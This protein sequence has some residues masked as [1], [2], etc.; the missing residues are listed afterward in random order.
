VTRVVP[1]AR[2][3][4]LG[5]ALL[6]LACG[7]APTTSQS[8]EIAVVSLVG[9]SADDA[10]VVLRLTGGVDLVDV[11]RASLSVAWVRGDANTTT[12]VIVGP[13]ADTSDVL[14]VRRRASAEPVGARVLEV[15]NAEGEVSLPSAARAIVRSGSR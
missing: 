5:L 10:G 14:L 4:A 15:A 7:E 6:G 9:I 3:G 8:E 1:A 12:V 11:G 2:L 13:L